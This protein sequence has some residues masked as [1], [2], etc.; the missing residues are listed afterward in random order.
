METVGGWVTAKW[1]NLLY[2]SKAIWRSP[3]FRFVD[4]HG[5]LAHSESFHGKNVRSYGKM[6]QECL[7][8]ERDE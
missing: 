8:Q 3:A 2:T 4:V 7:L 1:R 5:L 6:D